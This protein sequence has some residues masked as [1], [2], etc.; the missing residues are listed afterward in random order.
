M[1]R[2][3]V[4]RQQIRYGQHQYSCSVLPQ[5]FRQKRHEGI[6]RFLRGWY[7]PAAEPAKQRAVPRFLGCADCPISL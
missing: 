7:A 4:L 6:A 5:L 3:R 1:P 2:R